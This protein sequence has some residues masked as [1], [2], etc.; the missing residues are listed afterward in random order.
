MSLRTLVACTGAFFAPSAQSP[1]RHFLDVLHGREGPGKPKA[2][3]RD[4]DHGARAC[5]SPPMRKFPADSLDMLN[6]AASARTMRR[7]PSLLCLDRIGPA[8][9]RRGG[10]SPLRPWG[11]RACRDSLEGSCEEQAGLRGPSAAYRRRWAL[12]RGLRP[13]A[14]RRA[15]RGRSIDGSGRRARL[16]EGVPGPPSH[17]AV[18][19]APTPRSNLRRSTV[20][21]LALRGFCYG[22]AP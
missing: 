5:R 16:R 7:A 1:P 3:S 21:E 18:V 19:E 20:P 10:R 14:D 4:A 13:W 11:G 15:G 8:D 2:S 12:A 9:I 22:D 6:R 17:W